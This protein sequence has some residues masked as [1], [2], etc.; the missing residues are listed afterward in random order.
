M[1]IDV[2]TLEFIRKLNFSIVRLSSAVMLLAGPI[3]IAAGTTMASSV[4]GCSGRCAPNVRIIKFAR[5]LMPQYHTFDTRS[6]W[7]PAFG[8]HYHQGSRFVFEIG[9]FCMTR[10]HESCSW[11]CRTLVA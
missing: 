9:G 10:A 4:A 3:G 8:L 5:E 1:F 11:V 2:M 7:I 6:S